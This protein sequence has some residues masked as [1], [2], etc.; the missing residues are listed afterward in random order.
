MLPCPGFVLSFKSSNCTSPSS[1]LTICTSLKNLCQHKFLKQ[2]NI[3]TT[4]FF[5]TQKMI[6]VQLIV[7][8]RYMSST[9]LI[10]SAN[11]SIYILPNLQINNVYVRNFSYHFLYFAQ[12]Y[13]ECKMLPYTCFFHNILTCPFII[14]KFFYEIWHFFSCK[15]SNNNKLTNE[16]LKK[17]KYALNITQHIIYWLD[18]KLVNWH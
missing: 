17:R 8:T 2:N 7:N 18:L 13:N 3:C 5:T 4:C 9:G 16:D 12:L 6:Q 10:V 14:N 15:K 1:A 11:H